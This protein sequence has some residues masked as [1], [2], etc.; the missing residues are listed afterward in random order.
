MLRAILF[1]LDDTLL[2]NANATFLPAYFQALGQKFSHLI[3]PETFLAALVHATQ[4]VIANT[5]PSQT[6]QEVFWRAFLP[7]INLPEAVLMATLDDFYAHDFPKL[8]RYTRRRPEARAI[9]QQAIENGYQ[10]VIATNPLYP[11]TAILQRLTWAGVADLPYTLITTYENMHFTKPHPAYYREIADYLQ[12]DPVACLMVG[13][14]LEN[15]IAPA[16]QLGMRTF[17]VTEHPDD[18]HVADHAGPLHAVQ[19]ILTPS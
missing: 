16:R 15:D 5:D 4:Q 1:D 17:W 3:T 7:I 19:Q 18:S 10:V 11:E 6:N 14:D 8:R 13:D 9:V 12:Q 2:I